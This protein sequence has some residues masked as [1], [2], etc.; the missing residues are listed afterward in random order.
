M[1]RNSKRPV[2]GDIETLT[3]TMADDE[4]SALCLVV[5]DLTGR[6][7]KYRLSKDVIP[8]DSIPIDD[9]GDLVHQLN[10]DG[11][12]LHPLE[13][14]PIENDGN[15]AVSCYKAGH[16]PWLSRIIGRSKWTTGEVIK[17][18]LLVGVAIAELIFIWLITAQSG[19]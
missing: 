4:Y 9:G 6:Y 5:S 2:L 7:G 3:R 12:E 11:K 18:G 13:L 15:S 8:K 1:K 19:G 14:F 16:W 17:L 10:F